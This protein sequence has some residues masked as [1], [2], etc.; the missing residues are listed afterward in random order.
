M[1]RTPCYIQSQVVSACQRFRPVAPF[2]FLAKVPFLFCFF[3]K[4]R[5]GCDHID[6]LMTFPWC[7]DFK[8]VWVRGSNFNRSG[9]NRGYTNRQT[10]RQIIHTFSIMMS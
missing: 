9:V 4:Y 5:K 8:Y 6:M 3:V 7:T 2:F 10:D 1:G